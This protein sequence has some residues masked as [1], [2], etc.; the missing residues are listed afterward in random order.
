MY[1]NRKEYYD[2]GQNSHATDNSRPVGLPQHLHWL[3]LHNMH[4]KQ[5]E[6]ETLLPTDMLLW[7][8]L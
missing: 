3:Q 1:Q 8:V 5:F 7:V 4:R 2:I 6:A